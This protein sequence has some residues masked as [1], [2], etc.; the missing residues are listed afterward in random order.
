MTREKSSI[1][2]KLEML[3]FFNQRAGRELWND[4]PYEV[5]EQD[6]KDANEILNMAIQVIKQEKINELN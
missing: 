6:I 2:D 4:K 3:K 5:Q 1:I